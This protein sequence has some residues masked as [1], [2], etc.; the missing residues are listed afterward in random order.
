MKTYCVK[1]KEKTELINP[2][3]SKTKN[4]RKILK[5]EC[6]VCGSRKSLFLP[7]N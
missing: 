2:K 7:N 3:E 6:E 1:C 5:G 4:N